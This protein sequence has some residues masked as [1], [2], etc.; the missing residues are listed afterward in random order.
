VRHELKTWPGVFLDTLAGIKLFEIRVNDR[1][2][3]VGDILCLR[4]WSPSAQEYTGASCERRVTYLLQGRFGL[5]AN[6]CVMQ[7]EEAAEAP[8][9]KP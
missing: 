3:N 8:E 1:D 2:F 5:P 9:V 6:L 4:E 7:L